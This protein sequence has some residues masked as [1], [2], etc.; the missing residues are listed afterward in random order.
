MTSEVPESF[1]A[2]FRV[3]EP[4][5]DERQRRLVL[6]ARAVSLGQDGARRVAQAVGV[7][8]RTVTKGIAELHGGNGHTGNLRRPG[9]GRKSLTETDPDVLPALLGLM[10]PNADDLPQLQ[11]TPLSTRAIAA[12]LQDHGHRIS[13]WSVAKLLRQNGFRLSSGSR[14]APRDGR[15]D[16]DEQLRRVNDYVGRWR[17]AHLPVLAVSV[18]RERHDREAGALDPSLPLS[19]GA[20]R[21]I[22]VNDPG[23]D[24]ATVALTMSAIRVWWDQQP[25]THGQLLLVP[26]ATVWASGS[27]VWRRAVTGLAADTGLTIS[28]CYLPPITMRWVRVAEL[29]RSTVMVQR[30]GSACDSHEVELRVMTGTGPVATPMAPPDGPPAW[31]YTLGP[32]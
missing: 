15:P 16:R 21:V 27:R 20:A 7:H 18:T 3:I 5:L 11:W 12:E 2:E 19:A 1:I 17:A 28:V 6:A 22:D 23:S 4:H 29:I 26:D 13:A 14:S 10:E 30:A 31:N 32:G 24:D 25:A 9:G 8:P